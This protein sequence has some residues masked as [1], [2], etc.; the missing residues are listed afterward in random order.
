MIATHAY[1][2]EGWGVTYD[3]V[4]DLVYSTDGSSKIYRLDPNTFKEVGECDVK[5][6]HD[7]TS[8]KLVKYL[9][10]LE[11]IDGLVYAN[12]Y[13]LAGIK[14][15]PNYIVAIDPVDCEVRKVIPLFGFKE[16]RK[17]SGNVMNGIAE[18]PPRTG[19]LIITGKRWDKFFH[20]RLHDHEGDMDP[21]WSRNNITRFITLDLN[22][23]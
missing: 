13:I 10:E 5:I 16:H 14:D 2:H 4:A 17:N 22:F 18:Y 11:F 20:V 12:I 8:H 9:N 6:S 15:S 7:G 23:R 19:E 1:P 21:R 3:P